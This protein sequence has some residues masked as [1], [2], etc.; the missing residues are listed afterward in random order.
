MAIA[1]ETDKHRAIPPA[2]YRY[3]QLLR[4]LLR[5]LQLLPAGGRGPGPRQASARFEVHGEGPEPVAALVV[6]RP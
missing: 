6:A 3:L 2:R 5:L 4:L 1:A